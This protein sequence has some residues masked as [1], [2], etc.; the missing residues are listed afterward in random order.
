MNVLPERIPWG[1]LILKTK[2][3]CTQ[4]MGWEDSFTVS[5][6][7]SVGSCVPGMVSLGWLP[8]PPPPVCTIDCALVAAICL[9]ELSVAHAFPP[10]QH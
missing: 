9:S 5:E 8:P 10:H 3:L 7:F 4:I 1:N 2:I 6:G